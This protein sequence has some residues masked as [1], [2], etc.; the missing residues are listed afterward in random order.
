MRTVLQFGMAAALALIIHLPAALAQDPVENLLHATAKGELAAVQ[1]A[2]RAGMDPDTSDVQGHT[3]LIIAAREGHFDIA[4]FLLEQRARVRSV[5]A[6]GDSALM[7]ASLRGHLELV[8]LLV[9]HGAMVNPA[10]WTPLHY[11]AW[12]GQVQVCKLLL[13]SGAVVNAR[14]PNQSTPLMMAAREGH[15]GVLR[16]LLAAGADATLRN[17]ADDTALSWAL[18]YGKSEAAAVLRAAGALE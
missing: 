11:C 1:K 14:S 18:R 16:L 9:A 17:D 7:L 5:T 3:L 10:G 2:V 6:F 8:R 13:E 4:R 12:S 15:A